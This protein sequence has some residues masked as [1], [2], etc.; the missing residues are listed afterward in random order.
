[1]AISNETFK[2]DYGWQWADY[3]LEFSDKYDSVHILFVTTIC[4]LGF[5]GHILVILVLTRTKVSDFVLYLT[6]TLKKQFRFLTQTICYLFPYPIVN[7]Y[8]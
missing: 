5:I 7:F 6:K 3:L 1:M 2:K 8:F 4:S